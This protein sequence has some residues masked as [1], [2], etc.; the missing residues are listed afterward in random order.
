MSD[1]PGSGDKATKAQRLGAEIRAVRKARGM[2]LNAL[3]AQVSCSL[4]YLSR[5]ERGATKV[6]VEL[7]DEISAAL[8]VDAAWFFPKVSGS[9]P[10]ERTYVI[11]KDAR[12][13]LSDMYTRSTKELGFEDELLSSTISGECYLLL[14]RFPAGVDS[15]MEMQE[16]YEFEGEQHGLILSGEVR[17]KLGEE[18][19]VLKPGDSFSYPSKIAHRFSNN[20]EV[21]A[22]MVWSS[23]ISTIN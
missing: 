20:G 21:E 15:P 23:L 6:S 3:S 11:R 17:L 8:S 13:P 16:G 10:L 12:R 1:K 7:L 14:S 5:V 19:I 9:G 2:T 22:T 4:A 18:L